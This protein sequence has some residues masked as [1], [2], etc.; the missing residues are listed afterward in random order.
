MEG[1]LNHLAE[2]LSRKELAPPLFQRLNQRAEDL[3][4]NRQAIIKDQEQLQMKQPLFSDPKEIAQELLRPE[5]LLDVLTL[6]EKQ[7]LAR[8]LIQRIWWDGETL[9]L[10]CN[11]GGPLYDRVAL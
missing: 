5:K 10:C 2:L 11:S 6:Q 8:L 9:Q 3:E 4:R 7:I 1:E